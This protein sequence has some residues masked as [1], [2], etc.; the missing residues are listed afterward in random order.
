MDETLARFRGQSDRQQV[1]H[2]NGVTPPSGRGQVIASPRSQ[3]TVWPDHWVDRSQ[4][5]AAKKLGP[6]V[7]SRYNDPEV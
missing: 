2:Q 6:K 4:Y 3:V 7:G 5:A 1:S